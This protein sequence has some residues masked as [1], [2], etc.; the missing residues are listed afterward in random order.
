MGGVFATWQ[1]EYARHGIATFPVRLGPRKKPAVRNYLSLGTIRS[2]ALA[3]QF[4]DALAFGFGL[5]NRSGVT[6]V[7]VDT[8]D[9]RQLADAL[10]RHGQT[11][12]VIGTAKGFHCWY[13]HNGER[14]SIRPNRK[15]PIDILGAGF[16]VAP[17]SQ[18]AS[19]HYRFLQGSLDDLTGLPVLRNAP[20]LAVLARAQVSPVASLGARNDTLFRL[21]LTAARGCDDLDAL[22]DAVRA[23]N[24][25][26]LPPLGADEVFSVAEL[27]WRYE[28]EGR[29]Y[30][31]RAMIRSSTTP[32]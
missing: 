14:R 7:D 21:A 3:S 12:I 13:R 9:E 15:L 28:Q 10:D 20:A 17:P 26:Y 5:G 27:A 4:P 18:G 30:S 31:G 2:R 22:L 1:P 24:E 16:A 8:T 19:A 23:Q 29:N 11:P 32:K 25:N 6:V